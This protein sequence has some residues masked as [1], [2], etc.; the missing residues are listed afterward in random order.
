MVV[1]LICFDLSKPANVQIQQIA[2]WLD[3]LHSAIPHS[4]SRSKWQV[5]IVG[6]KSDLKSQQQLQQDNLISRWQSQ[7]P[8]LPFHNQHFAV[9]SFSLDGVSDL[10][11]ALEGVCKSIFKNHTFRVPSSFK[12]LLQ[13][14]QQIPK[15]ESI[16]PLSQLEPMIPPRMTPSQL[17]LALKYLHSIGQIVIL[18]HNL[19]CTS[20]K[21][22]PDIAAKFIS[23]EAVRLQLVKNGNVEI[24]RE[25]Q[26]G[27]ILDISEDEVQYDLNFTLPQFVTNICLQIEQRSEV[28]GV[29]WC[30]FRT[31]RSKPTLLISKSC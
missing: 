21:I 25:D 10:L 4:S 12:Q 23:P 24:L 19:V 16:I 30:L 1:Y 11:R 29:L 3:F 6:T 9:S 27:I 13:S 31:C 7:W 15:E 17:P 8:N 18:K 5:I 22:I 2:Y 20:P 14:L 26:I 28:V